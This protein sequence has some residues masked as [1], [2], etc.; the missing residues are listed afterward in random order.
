VKL[1]GLQK[2]RIYTEGPGY[3]FSPAALVVIT[4]IYVVIVASFDKYRVLRLLPLAAYPVFLATSADI[5]FGALLRKIAAAAP[6]VL[7]IAVWNPLFD[8]SR[9]EVLGLSVSCGWLSF[10]SA[11]FKFVLTVSA[12]LL[13]IAA[14]GFDKV[15]SALSALGLP[16]VLVTQL[17]LLNRYIRLLLDE[18]HNAVRARL[19][20]GGRITIANAGYIC[21]P[22]LMRSIDRSRRIRFALACRG[23]NGSLCPENRAR[24]S[25]SDKLFVVFWTVFLIAVRFQDFICAIWRAIL[26]C[27]G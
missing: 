26:R 1:K 22:L 14:V 3:I 11:V 15:C 6:A 25:L 24:F 20:R 12:T 27:L 2:T 19:F 21:G 4:L 16:D 8:A 9:C 7:L 18:T 10:A 13:M 17:F 23:Y 5:R